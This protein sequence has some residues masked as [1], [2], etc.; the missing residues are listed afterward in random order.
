MVAFEVVLRPFWNFIW[1][2][3]R[4][5]HADTLT[6]TERAEHEL[7]QLRDGSPQLSVELV[8]E[9]VS[10]MVYLEVTNIGA[11]AEVWTKMA[12]K[13]L[14]G[15]KKVLQARWDSHHD[16]ERVLIARKTSER[17]RLARRV[18]DFAIMQWLV[19][20]RSSFGPG[21]S[22]SDHASVIVDHYTHNWCV[23]IQLTLV[24]DPELPSGPIVRTVLLNGDGS[25]TMD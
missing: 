8:A 20:W 13:G 11:A 18:D 14:K 17:V 3:P 15:P 25:A 4:E 24:A 5:L 23:E 7:A 21:E 1:T 10:G 9:S 2:V 19:Y 12:P 16:K 22:A 6:R